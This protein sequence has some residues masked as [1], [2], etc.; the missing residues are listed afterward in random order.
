MSKAYADQNAKKKKKDEQN[1]LNNAVKKAAQTATNTVK[2]TTTQN[3]PK[4][5]ASQEYLSSR[6]DMARNAGAE[7]AYTVKNTTRRNQQYINQSVRKQQ[8]QKQA[9]TDANVAL[10]LE[11]QKRRQENR[12]QTRNAQ[13]KALLDQSKASR[14]LHENATAKTAI[15]SLEQTAGGHLKTIGDNA[16]RHSYSMYKD[17]V[18]NEVATGRMSEEEGEKYLK[19]LEASPAAKNYE[20]W[21][22]SGTRQAFSKI[23]ET[24]S[25]LNEMGERD[26]EE[27]AK[28]AKG[29]KKAYLGAV[30]SGVGMLT[31]LATGPAWALSMYSR[32]YGNNRGKIEALGGTTAQDMTNAGLQALKETATEHL[33]MGVGLARS[34]A[35]RGAVKGLSVADKVGAKILA[36]AEGRAAN[37]L[38]G[39]GRVAAGTM[40]ENVEELAGWAL[41]PFITEVAYGGDLRKKEARDI[42]KQQSAELLNQFPDE[43][44]ARAAALYVGSDEFIE[45]NKQSYMESGLP[46]KESQALAETMQEYMVA[47]LTNDTETMLEKEQEMIKFMSGVGGISKDSWSLK[48]LGETFA[49]TTLLTA[50]TGIPSAITTSQMGSQ[51]QS[52]NGKN[53]VQALAKTAINL[54]PEMSAKA[55]AMQDRM[56]SGKDLTGTQVYDLMMSA[57]KVIQDTSER[58]NTAMQVAKKGVEDENLI[59]PV[60]AAE[61]GSIELGETTDKKYDSDVEDTL[62]LIDDY[63]ARTAGEE[64][65]LQL[66]EEDKELVADTVAAFNA[67]VL[68]PDHVYVL[69]KSNQAAR[70]VFSEATGIDLD[71]YDVYDKNGKL[72]EV[73]SNINMQDA[74]F[75]QAAQ[76]YIES[77]RAETAAWENKERGAA[78]ASV[79]QRMESTGVVAVNNVLQN[80]DARD[81]GRYLMTLRSADAIYHAARNTGEAWEDVR[82]YAKQV[83]PGMDEADLRSVYEAGLRDREAA[84]DTVR[85][86]KTQIGQAISANIAANV[87]GAVRQAAPAL[88]L[89]TQQELPGDLMELM[90]NMVQVTKTSIILSDKLNADENGTYNPRTDTITLNVTKEGYAA[91]NIGY[92]FMHEFTHHIQLYAPEEYQALKDAVRRRWEEK[93]PEGFKAR[94]AAKIE[95]YK[96][97]EDLDEDRAIDELIADGAHEF[98]NDEQFVEKICDENTS[99]AKSIINAIRDV[100]HK[101]RQLF[102]MTRDPMYRQ[103]IFSQLDMLAEAEELWLRA[104]QA[105]AKN[106]AAAGLIQW[107]TQARATESAESRVQFSLPNVDSDGNVLSDSQMEFFKNS[108][109]RDKEGK[110]LPMYHFTLSAGFTVFDPTMSFD[111]GSISFTDDFD[112]ASNYAGDEWETAVDSRYGDEELEPVDLMQDQRPGYYECYLNMENPMEIDGSE[113]ESMD[114]YEYATRAREEGHDSLI[115]RNFQDMGSDIYQVF[116]SNQVKDT[117]NQE[118]T[119]D[120]DIR[121]SLVSSLEAVGCEMRKENGY[122]VVTDSNGQRVEE[123]TEEFLS[124]SPLGR[125]LNVAQ[126]GP[127][128]VLSS[129]DVQQQLSFLKDLYNMILTTQDPDLIWAVSGTIGYNPRRGID[130]NTA[131]AD[132]K[133][134]KSKFASIT[135]NADPQYKTTIDFTTICVKTQAIIDAMSRTMMDLHRGL[136]EHEIIDIVYDEVYQAKEQ[137]PCPVCYVFSRWVGLGNLFSSIKEFQAR[138]PEDMDMTEIRA[139]H[140]KIVKEVDKLVKQATGK[141]KKSGKARNELYAE[142]I[143]RKNKLDIKKDLTPEKFTPEDA[144]ELEGIER[145]LDVLDHW[146]WLE[147]TRLAPDYKPVPDD[148][149]FDINAGR[150]FATEY[151]AVWRFRTSRGP[152]L[153]KAAAPYS[154]SRLGD[155]IRGIASPSSIK[156]VGES[157]RIFLNESGWTKTAKTTY[158]KAVENAK[159]QNRMNGQRLQSTSDFRFEYGLDYLLSFIELGA[160]GAKAQMYTKVPEAVK[161]LASVGA[162]IN[163]SI[164]PKGTGVVWN[165]KKKKWDLEFSDVTGMAWEDALALSKAYDNVQPIL[166]AIGREHLIAA[167]AHDDITMIIPYHASGSSTARYISMMRTVKES[168]EDRTDFAEYEN[169]HEIEGATKEQKLCRKLRK[170]M[171]MGKKETLS[172]EESQALAKKE[173]AI[174]RQLYIRIY[175]KDENGNFAKPDPKYVENFDADGNDAD[176]YHVFLNTDQVGV[177]MPYEYWDKK[178]TRKDADKQG[179]AYQAYCKSLGITPVFS[180]WDNNGKYHEDMDFTKYPGYW[181][182]LIDRCMYNNDDTYHKQNPVNVKNV[183]LDM[184]N[185]DKMRDG[186]FKP[187]QVNNPEKTEEIAHNVRRRIAEETNR[188]YNNGILRLDGSD[189]SEEYKQ[190][191]KDLNS[192]GTLGEGGFTIEDYNNLP[193]VIKARQRIGNEEETIKIN[194][195]ERIAMREGWVEELMEYGSAADTIIDGKHATIYNG[196]VRQDKRLDIIVGLPS[197]G[198][199]SALVD[200]IS[201]KYKSRLLD[202]DEAKKL[203]PENDGG[204]GAGRV[205]EESSDILSKA[206][207]RSLENGDNIVLP[208]VGSK[209]SS[210]EKRIAAAKEFGYEV[211]LRLCSLPP[212]KAAARNMIRFVNTGRFVDLAQ[213]SLKY[214]NGPAEAFEAVIQKGEI[215][216]YTEVSNDV[217]RG[218]NPAFIRGEEDISYD[219]RDNG[220]GRRGFLEN[221]RGGESTSESQEGTEEVRHSLVETDADGNELSEGQTEFFK[222]SQARD[223]QGKLVPVYHTTNNGGFTVFDPSYSDD[224]RSLFF[225]SDKMVSATYGD[226]YAERIDFEN[227]EES[228]YYECYLNLQNP[229]IIEGKGQRW[230]SITDGGSAIPSDAEIQITKAKVY[231]DQADDQYRLYNMGQTLNSYGDYFQQK[232][233]AIGKGLELRLF[234]NGE[235]SIII[236]KRNIKAISSEINEFF[237]YEKDDTFGYGLAE[238]M[239]GKLKG[240]NNNIAYKD[241]SGLRE[242]IGE[243]GY[244]TRQ[245]AEYAAEHGHDGVIF[246]DIEDIGPD[247]FEGEDPISDIY[248]AFNG[249]QVKD[250]RN[251]NPTDDPDIRFSIPPEDDVLARMDAET[252]NVED[253]KSTDPVLEEG[254][255]RMARSKQDFFNTAN[256][257]WN[258]NWITG[259]TVFKD[260]PVK[261][262]IRELVMAA[263]QNSN[264]EYQYRKT[265]V[266]ETFVTAKKAYELM[267]QGKHTEAL[268]IL[269]ENAIDMIENVE[270]FSDDMNFEVYKEVRDYLKNTPISIAEEFYKDVDYA[271]FRKRNYSKLKLRQDGTPVEDV[272]KRLEEQWP[273]LFDSELYFTPA[274]QLLHIEDV[275]KRHMDPYRKAYR[276]DEAVKMATDIACD[277]Y[278]LVYNAEA[279]VSRADRI[280]DMKARYDQRTRDLK[281]RHAEAML[282]VRQQAEEQTEKQKQKT[283]EQKQKTERQKQRAEQWKE[284]YR[285]EKQNQKAKREKSRNAKEHAKTSGNIQQNYDWLIKRLVTPTKDKNIPEDFRVSLA[286]LLMTFDLQTVRSKDLEQYYGP[287]QKTL[288]MRELKDRL[289]AIAQEESGYGW[290]L[291]RGLEYRMAVLADKVDGQTI[292]ALDIEDLSTIDDLLAEI[293]HNFK[294]YTK[295]WKKGK[296]VEIAGIGGHQIQAME[297]RIDKYGKRKTY[298]KGLR[299]RMDHL[300]NE[301]EETPPYFFDRIDPT[302]EGLGAMYKELRR[303]EDRHIKNIQYLRARFTE[304]CGEFYQG[305]RLPGSE[306]ENW[307]DAANAQTFNLKNGPIT[308]TPAQI[309][310]LYC[311]KKR[312]QALGHILGNGIV[313]APISFTQKMSAKVKESLAGKNEQVQSVII[314]YEEV[315][316]IV[317]NLSE[318]QKRVAD[319]LQEMM[320]TELAEWGNEASMKLYNIKLF[321]DKDYFPIKSSKEVLAKQADSFDVQETIKNFGF[322]KPINRQANNAIVID[323]FFSVVADHCN[324]MSLYNAMAVPISDFM[325][326]YNYKQADETGRTKT[327]QAMIGEAFT[328]KAN[329]YIMKFIADVNGNVQTRSDA[330]DDMFSLTLANY[331]RAAIG[332][333]ARVLLQQPTAIFRA[334]MEISPRHF[335]HLDIYSGPVKIAGTLWNKKLQAEMEEMQ[336]H[337]PISAWK[338]WGNYQMDFGRGLEDI[339]MNTDWSARDILSMGLYGAADNMTWLMIWKAVK[340]EVQ[341]THP[342]LEVGSDEYWRVC[343]ERASEV[344][345]KTQVVDS[346]FHRSDA[347]RSSATLTKLSASFMAE[348]TLTFNVFRNNLVKSFEMAKD[349]DVTAAAK[350]FT[351]MAAVLALNAAAVSAS[352]A[353]WDAVRKKGAKDDDELEFWEIWYMNFVLNF[354]DNINLLNNIYVVKDILDIKEGIE[355]GFGGT[356]NMALEGFETFFTGWQ[357]AKKKL[358]GESDKSWYDILMNLLGGFGYITGVPTKT[359]MR[360]AKAIFKKLGVEVSAADTLEEENKTPVAF[361]KDGSELDNLLNRW[362]INLTK[363]EAQIKKAKEKEGTKDVKTGVT[364]Q[365][366]KEIQEQAAAEGLSGDEYNK[367]VSQL[368][369]EKSTG[370]ETKTSD[371][372]SSKGISTSEYKKIVKEAEE[373]GLSGDELH[374]YVRDRI[375]E[376][377]REIGTSA[378][379]KPAANQKAASMETLKSL[380]DKALAKAAGKSGKDRA[381]A[382]WDVV[383]DNYTHFVTITDWDYINEMRSFLEKNGGDVNAFD[384][385]VL[386]AAKVAYKKTLVEPELVPIER[387]QALYEY[388]TEH[389]MSQEYISSNILYKSYMASDLKAAFRMGNRQYIE[390]ESAVLFAAGLT[391]DD[392][393]KLYKYRNYG[394]KDYKGKYSDPKYAISTGKYSWPV[395][396]EITSGYGYRGSV[397]GTNPFHRGID[398]GANLGDPVAAADG[399]TILAVNL[400]YNGGYGNQVKIRHD[401]GTITWYNHLSA[402][403][404]KVGDTVGKGDQIGQVG[405]TGAST[406]PHL[407]FMVEVN[408]EYINPL[409]YLKA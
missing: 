21:Q 184:L 47:A 279:Y 289:A 233:D 265:L 320:S 43:E 362:G 82:A 91:R 214:L 155:T 145:R 181:K 182:T 223:E 146:S 409:E 213:T 153:G 394:A 393:Q 58:A 88:I 392:Y 130:E 290:V 341:E 79:S 300:V 150:K 268:G 53:A 402:A 63:N 105:A 282:K 225:S 140:A 356:S 401:D 264:T 101:L 80:V 209:V 266:D 163:C 96:G 353:I 339:M 343:N 351:K 3:K 375:S 365:E 124:A 22:Q 325:R 335:A 256:A 71:Q 55:Q 370:V 368:I 49:S 397:A 111:G 131:A 305:R 135:G 5:S 217:K 136:T 134:Q 31:D 407:D 114:P 227:P 253:M 77:A 64:E 159:R 191:V 15:G 44:S 126:S 288:R 190:A 141:K 237:G 137:V 45:Q 7:V 41:D 149:L 122:L 304:I 74:L 109:A 376:R 207:A 309:M 222:D 330:V 10:A 202:A 128:N 75:A 388:M 211:H 380:E 296:Q 357:Q 350:L 210:I 95:Q 260:A 93:D 147:R 12:Q 366:Y 185:S 14:K 178:S 113:M 84:E 327:V 396:G 66:K 90:N 171:L 292:D 316:E 270:F 379:S 277:L 262:Q 269:W 175:G 36:K 176:C 92:T 32:T 13:D 373:L 179:K 324:K 267:M 367:R 81:R 168:V 224:H 76:N 189:L 348:P 133:E 403:N 326:V 68:T 104:F 172:Y 232:A 193:E 321:K 162:E 349:G 308:L 30:N 251:L 94:I 174:L 1:L 387:Q 2:Q 183:D 42:L 61:N 254:R 39:L 187:L 295:A 382:L 167:M 241:S 52:Q 255:V 180:G 8:L 25:K 86:M 390:R 23:Y 250:T 318:D 235:E 192:G 166:V 328:R 65:R 258:P 165:E 364:P 108:K 78:L 127:Y 196:P 240:A 389:G 230:D 26:V 386:D 271:A 359:I 336:E 234:S 331:K 298:G 11:Q 99:L 33:F 238:E 283:E 338:A 281:A 110:L 100:L 259:G 199:S 278:D 158:K 244:S 226:E 216:G 208:I 302:G 319:Q 195:P 132:L 118:P 129:S 161:F 276:S 372:K 204:W 120:S 314:T 275:I 46:E 212:A 123:F 59:D 399:G 160:I 322:T 125:L 142:T 385:K 280:Q 301:A 206:F 272:Y 391:Q 374:D 317:S 400:G 50:T 371:S 247:F 103:A 408:G 354:Q 62:D 54:D 117:R 139:E 333:N 170:D 219:W 152:A 323:D 273:W 148:I 20:K 51:Y 286:H 274:D 116:S 73:G 342:D 70:N 69:S 310:S 218:E 384:Q 337:C 291:D 35:N 197:S 28:D 29:L 4:T 98:L 9:K 229:L 340:H 315:E 307:R 115:I 313:A 169:E 228:V 358:S 312:E 352:A 306:L 285:Q 344:F 346:V 334:F 345:D 363:K 329:D 60:T 294:N 156:K 287:A 188:Y 121:Y 239:L 144:K 236:V 24:G 406:G 37:F 72:D 361:I 257:K 27:A 381:D 164:M 215:D 293:V 198:K 252:E 404:V 107:D 303:G 34:L 173:N 383:G 6:R 157:K 311:L 67:G 377:E 138:Y 284:K 151:P 85:G 18:T 186:I 221:V 398:I 38:S 263:M 57:Q 102:G 17:W 297:D 119:D 143:D 347:M 378:P 299:S 112:F 154:P 48:E 19:N 200:P 395:N 177:M 369:S 231:Q 106:K 405:S 360:D 87:Q 40:E 261:R 242:A 97:H 355:K 248:I 220:E 194:T 56:D 201:H 89:D 249:S 205:H 246:H 203:I 245:W 332:S 16:N 243:I 83:A